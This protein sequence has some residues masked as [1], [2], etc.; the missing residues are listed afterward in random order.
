M[1]K[2][3][4]L[5]AALLAVFA[6]ALRAQNC[7]SV[8]IDQAHVIYSPQIV[9]DAT[10]TLISQ[11]ADVHVVTV[12]SVARYGGNLAAVELSFEQTCPSWTSNGRIKPNLFVVMVAPNDRA[13]NIFLGSYYSG[14][15]DVASTYSQLSNTYFRNRQWELG[16]AAVIQGTTN[17]ALSYHAQQFRSQQQVPQTPVY[18]P[19]QTTQTQTA[20]D[21]HTGLLIFGF[22]VLGIIVVGLIVVAI[23]RSRREEETDY[24]TPSTPS[25]GYTT[26]P[27][28]VPTSQTP[29]SYA[30]AAP[31]H[32]TVIN[33]NSGSGDGLLTG[34]VVG[35]MLS[36]PS[37]RTVYVE[38]P[39][40][41]SVPAPSYDPPAQAPDSTWEEPTQS[42]DTGFSAPEPDPTP[43]PSY[44]PPSMPDTDF[45]GGSSGGD[46]SF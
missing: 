5:A 36:R 33:N 28:F 31:S 3:A 26:D 9:T 23:V 45:G 15:F 16:L 38:Q 18:A 4:F 40:P 10:R 24:T 37:E 8:I 22:L 1:R 11:G 34:I 13:K 17:Q 27:D 25:T 12:D 43:E 2:L 6:P 20:S 30:A 42:Q 21:S 46:S 19:T 29:R 41:V 35:E 32:T 44:D 39:A 14:A 7:N